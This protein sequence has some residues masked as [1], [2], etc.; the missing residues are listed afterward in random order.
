MHTPQ[1]FLHRT[2]EAG[3]DT[4][5]DQFLVVRR[6]VAADPVGRTVGHGL[7]VDDGEAMVDRQPDR[8]VVHVVAG[9]E[10]PAPFVCVLVGLLIGDPSLDVPEAI[11]AIEALAGDA[12]GVQML[13]PDWR[14]KRH[15]RSSR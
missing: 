1:P 15:G 4:Q 7:D 10:R 13:S 8:H 6:D 12:A 9:F 14:R 11:L 2:G 3:A 5:T